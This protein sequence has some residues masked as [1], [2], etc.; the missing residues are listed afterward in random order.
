MNQKARYN[1]D[2]QMKEVAFVYPVR[3]T[4]DAVGSN[5]KKVYETVALPIQCSFQESALVSERVEPQNYGSRRAHI[6]TRHRNAA[7]FMDRIV[8]RDIR[9][10][11]LS[12]VE[13]FDNLSG[14][15]LYTLIKC[16]FDREPGS[17]SRG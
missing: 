8:I 5:N 13:K 6:Y 3:M 10:D 17:V 9:M 1:S 12:V 16:G 7:K 14:D 15:Y 11:V 4:K 2:L